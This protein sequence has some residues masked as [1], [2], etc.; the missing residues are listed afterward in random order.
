MRWKYYFEVCAHAEMEEERGRR[1]RMR[2]GEGRGEEW[3]DGW[4]EVWH[5]VNNQ[6][7]GGAANTTTNNN[8]HQQQTIFHATFPESYCV[9]Y[10]NIMLSHLRNLFFFIV[11]DLPSPKNRFRNFV[12]HST[13]ATNATTQKKLNQPTTHS[14]FSPLRRGS[15][16]PDGCL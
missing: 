10:T 14:P 12:L 13:T 7:L 1:R 5:N 11:V 16:W 4:C 6:K 15:W 3:S 9:T 8:N 2:V